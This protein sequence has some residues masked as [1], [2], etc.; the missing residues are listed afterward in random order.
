MW[1]ARGRADEQT[2]LTPSSTP[3]KLRKEV[4]WPENNIR[5]RRPQARQPSRN[6]NIMF[7][8]DLPPSPSLSVPH[9][10]LRRMSRTPYASG[11][12]G[13]SDGRPDQQHLPH[14]YGSLCKQSFVRGQMRISKQAIYMLTLLLAEQEECGH[15]STEMF[16]T[17][18]LPFIV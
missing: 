15:L 11:A 7:G 3:G 10:Y 8:L 17:F 12:R 13:D 16:V 4:P 5:P 2:E 18:P 6:S 14:I 9:T 1:A